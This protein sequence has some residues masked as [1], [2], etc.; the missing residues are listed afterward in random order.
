M[1]FS[2]WFV[3]VFLYNFSFL[4][5]FRLLDMVC[6]CW[7]ITFWLFRVHLERAIW[8]EVPHIVEDH[9]AASRCFVL[10]R[11]NFAME[12]CLLDIYPISVLFHIIKRN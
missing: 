7:F 11:F 1:Y 9:T 2:N 8:C 12:C 3:I 10:G 5:Q 4:I 6:F